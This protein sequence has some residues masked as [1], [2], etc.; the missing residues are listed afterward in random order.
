MSF[1]KSFSL[2]LNQ[3]G[4][5]GKTAYQSLKF[6]LFIYHYSNIHLGIMLVLAYACLCGLLGTAFSSEYATLCFLGIL[7]AYGLDN[8]RDYNLDIKSYKAPYLASLGESGKL[9]V[10]QFLL[11]LFLLI[12]LSVHYLKLKVFW[13]CIP[14]LLTLFH[15]F[16]L[17]WGHKKVGLKYIPYSKPLAIAFS[18][19]FMAGFLPILLNSSPIYLHQ[20]QILMYGIPFFMA[21]I[22]L[23]DYRD[24][25][26]DNKQNI[27]YSHTSSSPQNFALLFATAF[28]LYITAL[29]IAGHFLPGFA[30]LCSGGYGLSLVFL[31]SRMK[32]GLFQDLAIDS[33]AGLPFL[34]LYIFS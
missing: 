27:F 11:P 5:G 30:V 12:F 13:L 31:S 6:G 17:K 18:F 3:F 28:G 8:V 10:F 4:I 33:L 25:K 7:S 9:H 21:G 34:L 1:K 14:A 16:H 24:I 20:L 32:A 23:S 19:M 29:S 15:N 22:I 2:T 26:E